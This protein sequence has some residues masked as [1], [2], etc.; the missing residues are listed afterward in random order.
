MNKN[1]FQKYIFFYYFRPD[2]KNSMYIYNFLI[3]II[4]S[5]ITI[6][7][8]FFCFVN[9]FYHVEFRFHQISK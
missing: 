6:F 1:N 8:S 4:T 3:V 7:E 2:L 5:I 9:F